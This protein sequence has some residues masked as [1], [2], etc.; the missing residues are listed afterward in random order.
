MQL[1][2]RRTVHVVPAWPRARTRALQARGGA[3]QAEPRRHPAKL[4]TPS[5]KKINART[6][7]SPIVTSMVWARHSSREL[8]PCARDQSV[9]VR[10]RP[11]ARCWREDART[12]TPICAIC[13]RLNFLKEQTL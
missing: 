6:F 5:K 4:S 10:S 2:E 9:S 7:F 11:G 8:L 12:A 3:G 1:C 13:V